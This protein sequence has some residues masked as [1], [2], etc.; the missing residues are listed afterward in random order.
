MEFNPNPT[1]VE[2][3][4]L[5]QIGVAEEIQARDAMP[6][7][8][9]ERTAWRTANK[10]VCQNCQFRAICVEELRGGNIKA[11]LANDYE[12]KPKRDAIVLSN[13]EEDDDVGQHTE[14]ASLRVLDTAP[15]G[16]TCK[17]IE[18]MTGMRHSTAS[19]LS[20]LW[21]HRDGLSGLGGFRKPYHWVTPGNLRGRPIIGKPMSRKDVR[22][23]YLEAKVS[24]Y[25]S[26]GVDY[27]TVSAMLEPEQE[28]TEQEQEIGTHA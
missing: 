19:R 6:I 23:K 8:M 4:F 24:I 21:P 17:Q 5:E 26:L 20:P 22:I 12:P 14:R 9:V 13:G 2:R 18:R 7:E 28:R 25:E 11:A 1:R 10:M 16:L 27:P 3:T 15:E